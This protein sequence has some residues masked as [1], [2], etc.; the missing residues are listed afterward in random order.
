VVANSWGYPGGGYRLPTCNLIDTYLW[1]R[2]DLLLVFSAGTVLCMHVSR[3]L[4]RLT[5]GGG[6]VMHA[7]C[8]VKDTCSSLHVMPAVASESWYTT[9]SPLHACCNTCSHT[10]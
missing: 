9:E 5:K 8:D 1:H 7:L 6:H 3:D 2:Q 4:T 10:L